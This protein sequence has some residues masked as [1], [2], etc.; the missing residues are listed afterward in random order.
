[1][2]MGIR[3]ITVFKGVEFRTHRRGVNLNDNELILCVEIRFFDEARAALP[4]HGMSFQN[5]SGGEMDVD[6]EARSCAAKCA[7]E[8][9]KRVRGAPGSL[10]RNQTC[11]IEERSTDTVFDWRIQP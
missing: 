4:K 2:P 6:I 8:S 3:S 10:C 5:R 11:N 7:Q 1:M 9:V